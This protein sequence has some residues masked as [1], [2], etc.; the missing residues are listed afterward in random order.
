MRGVYQ[1][2]NK[3]NEDRYIGSSGN[4]ENR[5]EWHCKKLRKG[6][7]PNN[8]LQHA[9]NKYNEENFVFEVIEEV[10]GGNTVRLVRE[11]VY[12]DEGFAKGILYNIARNAGGGN[13]GE[14]VN[15]KLSEV[16]TGR[17]ITQEWRDNIGKAMSGENNP[18]YGRY[19]SEETKK[20]QRERKLGENNP[21]FGERHTDESKIKMSEVQTGHEVTQEA[22]NKIGDANAGS[23]P[24]L[25]NA[26]TQE[27][28]PAG[29]NLKKMC[30]EQALP[31]DRMLRLKTGKT[32][33]SEDGWRL[34]STNP[35]KIKQRNRKV[36]LGSENAAK[37]CPAFFNT[38]TKE[39]IP[40]GHN[41]TKICRENNLGY[42][43]FYRLK[44]GAT[45][46]TRNGWRLATKLKIEKG[47]K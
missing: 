25:F 30:R 21:F 27:Y 4:L 35:E 34:A 1:I 8:Y 13:L 36:H 44:S 12:L 45:K 39:N 24:A 42:G 41:L 43:K 18:F 29:R 10:S 33:Q 26:E 6:V 32:L 46:Q 19:H 11:Q 16:L 28:I 38:K 7:H 17:E 40:A 22:R 20:K 2:R 3:V 31:Y 23:Y 15:Q 5:W 9:W 37:P 47:G 14:E